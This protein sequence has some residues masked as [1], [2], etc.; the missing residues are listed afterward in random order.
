V[1]EIVPRWEWRTFGLDLGEADAQFAALG[2]GT[3]QESDEIYL[4]SSITD[5]VVKVR[6]GLM[7]IKLLEQ[8]N[9]TG[10]EQWRPVLKAELPLSFADAERVCAL[11]GAPPPAS[12]KERYTLDEFLAEVALPPP[13]LHR[14]PIH[15]TRSRFTVGGCMVELTHVR[16]EGIESRTVAIESEDPERVVAA[17]RSFGLSEYPNTSYPRWLTTALGLQV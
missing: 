10:L 13:G 14:V 16:L 11:L 9:E 15:K 2:P 3:V 7:D 17:V 1:G 12:G 6:A 4:V 8:V 5:K